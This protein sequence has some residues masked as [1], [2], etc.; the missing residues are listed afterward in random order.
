M[1]SN[2]SLSGGGIIPDNKA[3]FREGRKDEI[4]LF[5]SAVKPVTREKN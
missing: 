1:C 5:S 2:N 4:R 3:S